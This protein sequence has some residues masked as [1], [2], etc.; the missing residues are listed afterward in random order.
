[1]IA[2]MIE[3]EARVP[4]DRA[5][6][7]AVIYNRLDKGM[8]LGIDATIGYIDPDPSNG[9]TVSDFEIDSPYNTRLHTGLPPTPIA[10]PG[11]PS[12]R[13]ALNPADVPYLYYVL[14]SSNGAPPVQRRATTS[15]CPT[16]PSALDEPV[17]GARVAGSTRTVGIIGWPVSHSLSPA[18]H[19]AAFAALGIDWVYVPMPVHPLQLFAALDGLAALG[20]RR[21][22]RHD[23]AQGR[24]GGSG[25]RSVRRCPAT[26]RGE[27]ASSS[28]ANVFAERTPT[29]R[30]SSGS[31]RSTPGFDPSGRHALIFGAGGAARACALA[32]ARTGVASITVAAREPVRVTE[33]SAAALEGSGA[34]PSRPWRSRRPPVSRRT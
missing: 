13:A 25:R 7:A 10:S 16:R 5:K 26:A 15:S 9:L 18:I 11:I 21:S 27:H 28:T 2:S 20:I 8:P 34:C 3:R 4:S 29:P 22:E 31:C 24:G 1:M 30:G 17:P 32:L 19:N 6:I 12:F 33:V 14:C 23:A